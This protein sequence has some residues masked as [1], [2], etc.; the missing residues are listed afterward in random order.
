MCHKRF[1]RRL[2]VRRRHIH[3]LFFLKTGDAVGCHPKKGVTKSHLISAR[4]LDGAR[5]QDAEP[6]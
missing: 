3:V 2:N 5:A 6:N 4:D 1:A